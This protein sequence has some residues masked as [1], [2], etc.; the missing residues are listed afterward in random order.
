MALVVMAM[1]MLPEM[2]S[3]EHLAF[4]GLFKHVDVDMDVGSFAEVAVHLNNE[5]N[6]I[7]VVIAANAL[8]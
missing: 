2:G 7:N 8:A 6:C 3:L 4:L 5:V 1:S